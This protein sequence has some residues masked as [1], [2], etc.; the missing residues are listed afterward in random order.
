[1]TNDKPCF[2]VYILQS[3]AYPHRFYSGFSE[4]YE[5]RLREH[6][7]GKIKHTSKFG[8]WR[9]KQSFLLQINK[10]QLPLR[11]ISNLVLV[12]LL[13]KRDCDVI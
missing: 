12:D 6:N 7:S 2:H 9:V 8:P 4:D 3:I 11:I 10:E 1:M 5:R 13:R